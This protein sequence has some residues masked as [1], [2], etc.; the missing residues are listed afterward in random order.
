MGKRESLLETL[1]PDEAPGL[2][3]GDAIWETKANQFADFILRDITL[4]RWQR[5][6]SRFS[7]KLRK[8]M[9]KADKA[10]NG[11]FLM[12]VLLICY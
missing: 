4:A 7:K 3:F 9:E 6:A 8:L 10:Y 11:E 5:T 1:F 2:R 12:R